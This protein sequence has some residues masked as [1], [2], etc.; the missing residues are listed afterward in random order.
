MW[1]LVFSLMPFLISI[2]T[3]F[4]FNVI[5]SV[6]SLETLLFFLNRGLIYLKGANGLE[7]RHRVEA[8]RIH[9][10]NADLNF[11][12]STLSHST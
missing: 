7:C 2:E 12:E 4:V 8:E 11:C 10:E 1:A 5:L 6:F 3:L 9:F